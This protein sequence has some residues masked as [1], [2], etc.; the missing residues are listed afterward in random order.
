MVFIAIRDLFSQ[1]QIITSAFHV[2]TSWHMHTPHITWSHLFWE[3]QHIMH[4]MHHIW[5]TL[6]LFQERHY[7]QQFQ[8]SPW[9][10]LEA[11][12]SNH[13]RDKNNL[14]Q[15]PSAILPKLIPKQ[16]YYPDFHLEVTLLSRFLLTALLSRLS[17]R[18]NPTIQVPSHSPTIQDFISK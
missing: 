12:Q 15:V 9:S 16:P 5:L 7:Y 6:Y 2:H 1:I 8:A 17:F 11:K 3:R 10:T 13:R 4:L 18:S 14:T